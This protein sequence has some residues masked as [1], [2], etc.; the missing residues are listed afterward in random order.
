MPSDNAGARSRTGGMSVSLASSDGR[1]FGGG[2]VGLLVAA[3][4]IQV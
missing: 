3:S 1:V 2:V 4:S